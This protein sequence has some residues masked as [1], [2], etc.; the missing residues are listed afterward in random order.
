[1]YYTAEKQKM[2]RFY[3]GVSKQHTEVKPMRVS[4]MYLH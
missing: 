2:G 3:H 4:Y 1:M